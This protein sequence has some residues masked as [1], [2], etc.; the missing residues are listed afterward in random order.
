MRRQPHVFCDGEV[1]DS[2][3]VRAPAFPDGLT[4]REV[5]VIR[6]VAAGRTDREIAEELVIG[7]RTASTHVANILN[8]TGSAN[9]AEAASYATR[10]GLAAT[11][12]DGRD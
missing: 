11:G 3:P 2:A 6:L 1:S 4:Q 9:R 8:K 10:H 12:S 7:F 5:E